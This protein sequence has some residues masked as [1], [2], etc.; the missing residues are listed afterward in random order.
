[1]REKYSDLEPWNLILQGDAVRFI[2]Q[3]DPNMEV[4]L[5]GREH[6]DALLEKIEMS[7]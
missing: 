4:N 3:F 2:D 7:Q 1:M 5:G 6:F